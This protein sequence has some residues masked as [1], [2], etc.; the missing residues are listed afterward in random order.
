MDS[1]RQ[2][3][4]GQLARVFLASALVFLVTEF[5][6]G[7]FDMVMEY[8]KMWA[9]IDPAIPP[10]HSFSW[11]GEIVLRV[12]QSPPLLLVLIW[13]FPFASWWI[14]EAALFGR[15][16]SKQVVLG[17]ILSLAVTLAFTSLTPPLMRWWSSRVI[18]GYEVH[19]LHI[20]ASCFEV[21]LY[22]SLAVTSICCVESLW[23]STHR[24]KI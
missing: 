13:W 2:Y 6:R 5:E 23:H 7:A 20:E 4:I 3:T 15:L 1:S 18:H 17:W 14:H 16:R 24:L 12:I 21:T 22:L 11:Y 9:G 10:P 19:G 8:P